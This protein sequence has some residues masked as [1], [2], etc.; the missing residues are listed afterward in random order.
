MTQR[1][2]YVDGRLYRYADIEEIPDLPDGVEIWRNVQPASLP[3]CNIRLEKVTFELVEDH[4]S[5]ERRLEP[6]IVDLS[7]D[8][9]RPQLEAMNWQRIAE[10][11]PPLNYRQLREELRKL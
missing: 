3:A 6:V 10:G 1:P 4:A 8:E 9:L 11:K 2:I 5:R 7:D